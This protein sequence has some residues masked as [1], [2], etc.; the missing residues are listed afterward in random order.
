MRV[1]IK[2]RITED[3]NMVF[4]GVSKEILAVFRQQIDHSN[5]EMDKTIEVHEDVGDFNDDEDLTPFENAFYRDVIGEEI[6]EGEMIH[7]SKNGI[8]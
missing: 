1:P 8:P 6:F 5:H 3:I 7:W 4:T 2:D